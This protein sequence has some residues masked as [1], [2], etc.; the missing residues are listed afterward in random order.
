MEAWSV[1]EKILVVLV[2]PLLGFFL[3]AL[4]ARDKKI[5]DVE[6]NLNKF[7]INVANNYANKKDITNI[8]NKLDNLTNLILNN[9]ARRPNG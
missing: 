5:A 4:N 1:L 7:Q 6:E 3:K 2:Y 8:E 9:I